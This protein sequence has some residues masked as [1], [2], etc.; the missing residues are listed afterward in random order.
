MRWII[1]SLWVFWIFMTVLFIT[2]EAHAATDCS[3]GVLIPPYKYDHT[4][5]V[6]V[7]HIMVPAKKLNKICHGSGKVKGG[8][9]M[10]ACAYKNNTGWNEILPSDVSTK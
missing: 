3:G 6:P 7:K 8:G 4:P 2:S 5:T 9:I 1:F 10:Y